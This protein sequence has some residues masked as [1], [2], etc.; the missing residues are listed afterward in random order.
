[1]ASDMGGCSVRRMFHSG[2]W[3]QC[4]ALVICIS[5][6][7]WPRPT[8]TATCSNSVDGRFNWDGKCAF[9]GCADQYETDGTL[10]RFFCEDSVCKQEKDQLAFTDKQTCG[11]APVC[12]IGEYSDDARG[13]GRNY[14][15]AEKI[16]TCRE[17]GFAPPSK[18]LFF[19]EF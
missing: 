15:T 5:L 7:F 12:S 6:A 13:T 8:S 4:A 18:R 9:E 16:Y 11:T 1:M 3:Q 17:V 2:T 19:F 14:M 10:R